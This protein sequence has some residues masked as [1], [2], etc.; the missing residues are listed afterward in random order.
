MKD[1]KYLVSYSIPLAC[2]LG[3]Y[4]R[5]YWV[6]FTPF[7]AFVLIPVL[8]IVLPIQNEN[9][10][11]EEAITKGNNVFFEVLLYLNLPIVYGLLGWFLWSISWVNYWI[12]ELIGL[13]ISLGVVLGSNGINVAHELGHRQTQ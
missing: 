12:T 2:A 5:D 1:L 4:L 8:E 6:F 9:L 10:S 3:L 11:K 13:I 7:F